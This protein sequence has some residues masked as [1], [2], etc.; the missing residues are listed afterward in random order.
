[1]DVEQ[2]TD[3]YTHVDVHKKYKM[4]ECGRGAHATV[5][6]GI[7]I[8]HAKEV[9][10]SYFDSKEKALEFLLEENMRNGNKV[11]CF[12]DFTTLIGQQ[13]SSI[14]DNQNS[15]SFVQ[16]HSGA[17]TSQTVE[18]SAV[19]A[20]GVVAS[21]VVASGGEAF[22]QQSDK[23]S[24]QL[25][26]G[27]QSDKRRDAGRDATF[28]AI[29][30]ARYYRNKKEI[31]HELFIILQL[32]SNPHIIKHI[33]NSCD[34]YHDEVY[35]VTEYMQHTIENKWKLMTKSSP[36]WTSQYKANKIRRYTRGL[37]TGIAHVHKNGYVH[38][39]IK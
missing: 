22:C 31:N 21:G 20:S 33:E 2:K 3:E 28:V 23:Q 14:V 10:L 19:V 6:K 35:I 38:R 34:M 37:L 9:F 7:S 4:I 16:Q 26:F 8:E 13:T 36:Y 5:Y 24:D 18:G 30:R 32:Q 39:D 27:K 12:S 1:M 29:K 11:G 15:V 17:V 25:A